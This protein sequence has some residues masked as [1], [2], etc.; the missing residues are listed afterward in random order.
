MVLGPDGHSLRWLAQD[1]DGELMLDREPEADF[2]TR[3]WLNL[4]APLAPEELL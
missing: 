2:W 4:L 3:F 1:D